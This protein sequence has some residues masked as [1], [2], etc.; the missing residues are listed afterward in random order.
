MDTE[1][2]LSETINL[3]PYVSFVINRP[4]F[5]KWNVKERTI[6]DNELV[7]IADGEGT[8]RINKAK[9]IC[10]KGSLLYLHQ[11]EWHSLRSRPGSTINFFSVHFSYLCVNHN[12]EKWAYK[13]D[14]N[15][16]I[17]RTYYKD[18]GWA[19]NITPGRLPFPS[20]MSLSEYKNILN[21][22]ESLN[23]T[24]QVKP[25]GYSQK[26][27]FLCL[28][29]IYLVTKNLFIGEQT[30]STLDRVSRITDFLDRNYQRKIS[31]KEIC[32]VTSL[33]ESNTIKLF[34]RNFG[35][36]PINYLN[37]I[38]VNNAKEQLLKTQKS[39]KEIAYL[40]G[41]TDEYY[42]SRVFKKIENI[43]PRMFRKTLLS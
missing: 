19:P 39:I 38:R 42:F 41:F 6:E 32:E 18:P 26:L 21:I 2:L 37:K 8:L 33:T 22:F 1:T 34:R 5:R 27:T 14:I 12:T 4:D 10:K 17:K 30:D 25:I 23:R 13:T 9:Y 7:L 35:L 43:S 16:Y 40:N 24:Y 20:H 28:E 29:L 15:Y 3:V 31:L 36:T 11:N